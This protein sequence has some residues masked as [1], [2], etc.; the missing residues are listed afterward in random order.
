MFHLFSVPAATD[1]KQQTAARE[2]VHRRH[3]FGQDNRIPFNHET[4]AA[5]KF[6][7]LCSGGSSHEG[8]KEII[9]V[10]VVARQISAHRPG[11]TPAGGDMRMLRKPYRFKATFFTRSR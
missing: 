8:N 3:L 2:L 10:P 9:G 7:G 1:A 11:A 4:N 5:A 6:D